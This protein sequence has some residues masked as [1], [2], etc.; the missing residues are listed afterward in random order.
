MYRIERAIILAA[1][2]GTRLRPLTIQTPKPLLTVHGVRIIA[3]VIHALRF[4]GIHEIYIVVGYL[5]EAFETLRTEFPGVRL[6][7]NP[8]Y[9]NANNISSLYYAREHLR[10]TVIL[11][12]D[13]LIRNPA[14]F[15]PEF[16]RSGYFAVPNHGFTPEWTLTV[17]EG[18]IRHCVR[19]GGNDPLQ[20]VS[21][22]IWSA[23]DGARLASDVRDAYCQQQRRDIY[24]DDVPLFLFPAH[25]QLGVREVIAGD[26]VEIDTLAELAALDAAY[27]PCLTQTPSL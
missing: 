7:V 18:I 21:A 3:S 26:I 10:N 15:Q 17:S 5:A 19:G 11:D 24:W 6:I 12:G 25:Y 2:S 23:K 9:Q 1:G 20:L 8:D 22:S 16:T 13:Q 14:V 4:N 27:L